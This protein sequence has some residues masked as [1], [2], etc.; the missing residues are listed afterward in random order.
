M[1]LGE[2][3][4]GSEVCSPA[5]PGARVLLGLPTER[6]SQCTWTV[7]L[8]ALCL[9]LPTLGG[10][11]GGLPQGHLHC[12]LQVRRGHAYMSHQEALGPQQAPSGGALGS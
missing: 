6:S 2:S 1:C 4:D 11:A 7:S 10:C 5:G 8:H 12:P 9:L 3:F